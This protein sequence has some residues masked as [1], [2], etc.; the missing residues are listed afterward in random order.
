MVITNLMINIGLIKAFD[1]GLVQLVTENEPQMAILARHPS[2][3]K[4]ESTENK[5]TQDP[6]PRLLG[7]F[8]N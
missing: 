6:L 4:M 5:G 8:S 2:V 1:K 7:L 3:G